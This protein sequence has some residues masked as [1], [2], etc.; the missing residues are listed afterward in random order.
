MIRVA[1]GRF[2]DARAFVAV[3]NDDSRLSGKHGNVPH[4]HVV[5][6]AAPGPPSLTHDYGDET[7]KMV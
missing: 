1:G 2:K 6:R 4:H 5:S 7:G 3:P